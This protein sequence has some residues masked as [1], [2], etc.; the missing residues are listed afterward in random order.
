MSFSLSSVVFRPSTPSRWPDVE[1]LFGE[2]GACGGCW[3]MAWRLKRA[4]FDAGKGASNRRRLRELV[5]AG[6][7]P[8][9]IAYLGREPIG[10]CAVAPRR[11]YVVLERSKVLAPVD[12]RPVWSVSCLFVLKPHRRQGLSSALLAA[13]AEFAARQGARVVEGYPVEPSTAKMPDV[14]AWTGLPSAFRKAGFVEVARRSPT[15]PIMRKH[16]AQL[17]LGRQ[18]TSTR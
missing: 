12:D 7:K 14:F 18:T 2:R 10:W 13:A 16:V 17:A 11:D 1:K 15:R 3:C 9:V 4:E 5:E 8:G 6:R